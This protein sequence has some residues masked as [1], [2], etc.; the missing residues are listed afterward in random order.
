MATIPQYQVLSKSEDTLI[1][2]A[3]AAE[4]RL[5]PTQLAQ[6]GS[7]MEWVCK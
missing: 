1:Q 2:K 5:R 6:D 3:R 4:P 7:I